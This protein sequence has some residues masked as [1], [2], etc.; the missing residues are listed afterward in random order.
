MRRSRLASLVA[1]VAVAAGVGGFLTLSPNA[2]AATV[3][4]IPAHVFA[5]YFEAYNGDS[6]SSLSASSGNKFL[7][8]AFVQT[9]S[10]GSCTVYWNG[11][12]GLPIASS[13]FGSDITTIRHGGGDVIPSFG[14]YAAADGGTQIAD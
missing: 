3:S 6:M 14:G 10:A 2:E 13:S 11:D 12:T 9:P 7:T 1:A 4:R 8:M 5:P